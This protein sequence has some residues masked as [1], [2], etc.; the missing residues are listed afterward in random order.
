M[1]ERLKQLS[2]VLCVFTLHTSLLSAGVGRL[3][4]CRYCRAVFLK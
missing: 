4:A 3:V 1:L 2:R